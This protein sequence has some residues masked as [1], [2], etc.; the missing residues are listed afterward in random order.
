MYIYY[1]VYCMY[2]HVHTP[3]MLHNFR[4]KPTNF[5]YMLYSI[6]IL[7]YQPGVK[8]FKLLIFI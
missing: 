5:I 4:Q 7:N 3:K 8:H 1:I 6:M 2:I